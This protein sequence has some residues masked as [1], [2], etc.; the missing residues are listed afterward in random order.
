MNKSGQA[1][2]R[3]H[4][5]MSDIKLSMISVPNKKFLL[6]KV[7]ECVQQDDVMSVDEFDDDLWWVSSPE[8][9]H[10]SDS[11]EEHSIVST[12]LFST[13]NNESLS[14]TTSDDQIS[15][16]KFLSIKSRYQ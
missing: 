5:I 8:C 9:V 15:S 12:I 6:T 4:S 7:V 2:S 16:T 11:D 14:S 10:Y 1:I 13:I 3:V